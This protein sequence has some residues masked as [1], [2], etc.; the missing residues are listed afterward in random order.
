M[1]SNI[2]T[3]SQIFKADLS[4]EGDWTIQE[5]STPLRTPFCCVFGIKMCATVPQKNTTLPQD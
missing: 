4:Q 3:P 1:D 2:Q 5:H